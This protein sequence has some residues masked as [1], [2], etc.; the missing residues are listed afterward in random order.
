MKNYT[1]SLIV[2]DWR[3]IWGAYQKHLTLFILALAVDTVST[4]Y[5]MTSSG[6]EQEFHPLVRMAAFA[7]GPI[8]GPVLAAAYKLIAA[9]I[10]VLYW[11]KFAAPI[12]TTAA[13]FYLFAAFYN[14]FA[15]ELYLKGLM[16]WLPF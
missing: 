14:Y 3:R 12:L 16:P 10:V 2:D 1:E 13:V 11:H 8:A 7:Y 15:I 5:F 6:P 9:L 4:I